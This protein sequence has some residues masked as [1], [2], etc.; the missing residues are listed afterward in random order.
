MHCVDPVCMIVALQAPFTGN[1]SGGGD[2][3]LT[4]ISCA[5]CANSC[6]DNIQMVEIRDRGGKF[7]VDEAT[8]TPI[9][10]ASKCDLCVD[11]LGGPACV[12]ACPHDALIRA[13]M[14]EI[15]KLSRWLN[16]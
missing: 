6:H 15:D 3:D 5:T 9:L 8:Q 16:G 12:R 1:H 7:I 10:K 13:N 2:Y 14:G 11:Q 4:C